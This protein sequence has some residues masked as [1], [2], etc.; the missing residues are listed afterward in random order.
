MTTQMDREALASLDRKLELIHDRVTAVV[1][2]FASGFYLCGAG[3]LGKSYS[4]YQHLEFLECDHRFFN[5]R[6]TAKGLF[7]ALQRAPESIHILEDLERIV[8]DRDA[9]NL[10][11]S[12]LWSQG[13]R[14]RTLTW[15]TGDGERRF[16]FKGGIIML[17]NRPVGDLP[18]LRALATRIAVHKLEISDA[19]MA[20]QMRRIAGKG[21]KRHQHTLEP[22]KALEVCEYVINECR[23]ANGPLAWEDFKE[24]AQQVAETLAAAHDKG[25]LHRD[26]KP[27]NLLLRKGDERWDVRLIDFGPAA[28]G[29]RAASSRPRPRIA[30]SGIVVLPPW[31]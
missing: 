14:D 19:E 17:A 27:A 6:L 5:S 20:A 29:T 13:D 4:L 1:R 8:T 7:A 21:W 18:E 23:R 11:R 31:G 26:V 15:T 2:G 10:L 9:Q 16:T 12:A 22:E 30:G 3:G 24:V 28:P 25:I